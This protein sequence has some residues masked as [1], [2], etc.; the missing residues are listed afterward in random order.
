M[1]EETKLYRPLGWT[2]PDE[3]KRLLEFG[4]SAETCD[5]WYAERFEATWNQ[6]MNRYDYSET[7]Y[8]YLSFA[9]PSERNFSVDCIHDLP[10]WSLG[11]LLEI[12]PSGINWNERFF[13]YNTPIESAV[14]T[15][16]WCLE[17]GYMAKAQEQ[18]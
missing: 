4:I 12:I 6:S 3:S 2:T 7:P 16:V 9:K 5:L 15:A 8:Y 18:K 11:Q 13:E 1:I 14:K 17:N 10:C